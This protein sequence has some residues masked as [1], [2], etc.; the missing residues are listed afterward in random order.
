MR[1]TQETSQRSKNIRD[2]PAITFVKCLTFE[3]DEKN[4]SII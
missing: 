2:K 3:T 4:A 1:G